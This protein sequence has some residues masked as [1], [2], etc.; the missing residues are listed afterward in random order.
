MLLAYDDSPYQTS[1]SAER[2]LRS[3]APTPSATTILGPSA[4]NVKMDTS[5]KVMGRPA[6]VSGV[7]T[8]SHTV[9]ISLVVLMTWHVCLEIKA[10]FLTFLLR[11]QSTRGRLWGW[12]PYVWH[13]WAC[14]V[15]LHRG[16]I[17]HLLL[18]PRVHRRWSK[19]PRCRATH[20]I[21]IA[22]HLNLVK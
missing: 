18:P 14:S 12:H 9:T 13:S 6:L 16:L 19:L 17:L 10:L 4:V 11:G 15:Q 5:S 2:L 8:L 21:C 20:Y 22:F 3:V 1:M 7:C